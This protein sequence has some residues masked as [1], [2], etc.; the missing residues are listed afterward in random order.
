[1]DCLP[2]YFCL[3][4][5][6]MRNITAF[7]AFIEQVTFIIELISLHEHLKWVH[8]M[9]IIPRSFVFSIVY[10]RICDNYIN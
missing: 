4:I 3:A 7:N 6:I 8:F 5:D 2:I 1:M 9:I 10:L